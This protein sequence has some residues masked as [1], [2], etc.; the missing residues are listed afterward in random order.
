MCLLELQPSDL[1]QQRLQVGEGQPE[2][3]RL[4]IHH[5]LLLADILGFLL[6]QRWL[7]L[8]LIG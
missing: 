5:L 6:V 7:S 8:F 3:I 1:G 2:V 4:R